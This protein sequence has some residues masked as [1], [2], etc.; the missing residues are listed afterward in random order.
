MPLRDDPREQEYTH[1]PVRAPFHLEA[2]VRVLQRRP[3]NLIDR[4]EAQRYR[5]AMRVHGNLI[6]IEVENCGTVAAPD[7]RL[8]VPG[9]PSPG[10]M[11]AAADRVR[12]ILGSRP[13]PSCRPEPAPYG[14]RPPS[15]QI[16]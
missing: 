4:W 15:T 16:T 8:T 9:R 7:L 13:H 12:E 5:R 11:A 3:A 10:S 1:L 2:T 6:L 14:C